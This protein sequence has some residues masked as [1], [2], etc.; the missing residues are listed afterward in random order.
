MYLREKFIWNLLI[1]ISTIAILYYIYIDYNNYES[2]NNLWD[3]YS[4]EELGT[5]KALED[6]IKN[7]ETKLKK[8]EDYV[9]NF[10]N[11]PTDLR[12][13]IEIEG[14]EGYFG[15]SSDDIKV[16]GYVRNRAIVQYK[17]TTYKVSLG[18]TIAGGEIIV[19]NNKELV[20][21]RD[22]EETHYS[23]SRNK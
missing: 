14:M 3:E 13:I 16:Y 21:L 7:L 22:D 2:Y 20:F 23:L 5:D 18:D 11:N 8:K 9:F 17:G 4:H 10:K 15:I 19:L 12:R 6:K 1:G